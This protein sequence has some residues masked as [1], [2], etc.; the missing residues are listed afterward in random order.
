MMT[1]RAVRSSAGLQRLPRCFGVFLARLHFAR[2]TGGPPVPCS[3]RGTCLACPPAAAA[4]AAAAGSA[5]SA[6]SRVRSMWFL[7]MRRR[8]SMPHFLPCLPI[9]QHPTSSS[10]SSLE[11]RFPF[12]NFRRDS[13]AFQSSCES[14]VVHNPNQLCVT[15]FLLTLPC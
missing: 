7:L 15:G 12:A 3:R 14:F 4:P 13:A 9:Q 10:S 6:P 11:Y 1:S 2:R 5:F 8:T